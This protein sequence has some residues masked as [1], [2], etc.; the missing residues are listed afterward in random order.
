MIQSLLDKY[1]NSEEPAHI[2]LCY[3]LALLE[4]RKKVFLS[5]KH[6]T[7]QEGNKIVIYENI[8]TGDTCII[9]DPGLTLAE[10]EKVQAEVQALR[11]K[12]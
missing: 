6:T 7:D 8:Q 3:I 11:G 9:R 5:R 4:E 1:I 2:N 12:C 10:A